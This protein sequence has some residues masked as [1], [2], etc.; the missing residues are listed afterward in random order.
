MGWGKFDIKVDV[1]EETGDFSGELSI[2]ECFIVD[3]KE[4]KRICEFVRGYCEGVI[5]TLLC[6]RV[7]LECIECPMK[8]RFKSVCKFRILLED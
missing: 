5:E 3:R 2:N 7:T 1:N 8:N 6:I 4:R